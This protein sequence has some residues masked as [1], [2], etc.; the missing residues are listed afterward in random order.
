MDTNA[1]LR[2]RAKLLLASLT[3]L[4]FELYSFAIP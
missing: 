4:E 2:E 1:R 3:L